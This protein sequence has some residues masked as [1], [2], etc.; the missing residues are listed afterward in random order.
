MADGHSDVAADLWAL[1]E[2]VLT[3]LEPVLRQAVEDQS[4]RP[5]QGC[6]WCPVCALA[7]LMRG[8][9]HDLIT[10]VASEG[11]A[12]LALLRQLMSD[13]AGSQ[14]QHSARPPRQTGSDATT[15][16]ENSRAESGV[17]HNSGADIAQDTDDPVVQRAKFVP[18]TVTVKD[19]TAPD[20]RD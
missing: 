12:V 4:E 8:E 2:N 13:H 14:G 17:S 10:L 11:A 6:S 5:Q 3:R 19:P 7:A 1:A 15:V 18:I 9:Q 20:P 16:D